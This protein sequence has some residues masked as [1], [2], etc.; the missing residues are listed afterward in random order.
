MEILKQT[1]NSPQG[2]SNQDLDTFMKRFPDIPF[3]GC[4]SKDTIPPMKQEEWACIVN[5]SDETDGKGVPLPGTHWVAIGRVN[6]EPWY[7]DS[8]GLPPPL[9]VIR[10][11][12]TD[13]I[14]QSEKE[15][16]ARESK[17]CGWYC[18]ACILYLCSRATPVERSMDQFVNL[19][20]HKNYREND[21]ILYNNFTYFVLIGTN[22]MVSNTAS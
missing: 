2:T 11:F 6:K 14:V 1:F 4:F 3:K 17:N 10:Y 12:Q 19:F 9:D 8:F 20:N 7:F 5:M 15:I 21:T 13:D 16:Q 18:V 22:P